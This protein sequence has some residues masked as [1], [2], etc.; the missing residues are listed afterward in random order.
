LSGDSNTNGVLF[1]SSS[2]SPAS[3]AS[4]SESRDLDRCE[5]PPAFLKDLK[6]LLFLMSFDLTLMTL[7]FRPSKWL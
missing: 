1:I 2:V 5:V 3:A 6:A 4:S 7:P